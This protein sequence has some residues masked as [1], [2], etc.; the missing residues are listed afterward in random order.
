M[1]LLVVD[2]AGAAVF[3][4]GQGHSLDKRLIVSK[5]IRRND[6][7]YLGVRVDVEVFA[8]KVGSR[9]CPDHDLNRFCLYHII[10]LVHLHTLSLTF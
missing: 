2:D 9:P 10:S 6:K 1:L 3:G 7:T 8:G 4:H 5:Q